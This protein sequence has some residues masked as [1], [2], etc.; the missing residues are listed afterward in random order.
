MKKQ[1]SLFDGVCVLEI[2]TSTLISD[3][4]N[5]SGIYDLSF[6]FFSEVE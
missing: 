1:H 2:V 5:L 6:F 4:N 3:S